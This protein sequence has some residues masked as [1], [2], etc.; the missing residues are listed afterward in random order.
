M[1]S[2]AGLG[3]LPADALDLLV[4]EESLAVAGDN[5][6]DEDSRPRKLAH[7]VG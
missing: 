3:S 1:S 5:R 4:R 6:R 2:T 7:P